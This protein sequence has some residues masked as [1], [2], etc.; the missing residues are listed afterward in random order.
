MSQSNGE[1][2]LL[3]SVEKARVNSR[4]TASACGIDGGKY[5]ALESSALKPKKLTF[6]NS[7]PRRQASTSEHESRPEMNGGGLGRFSLTLHA[8]MTPRND[9]LMTEENGTVDGGYDEEYKDVAIDGD[10]LP[11]D[12]GEEVMTFDIEV[13]QNNPRVDSVREMA[14]ELGAMDSRRSLSEILNEGDL[15]NV[16]QEE[17]LSLR[18]KVWQR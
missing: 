12:V 13:A 1:T 4:A 3:Q 6:G 5:A 16:H 14:S 11:V 17:D 8:C 10:E 9:I 2:I 7:P 18:E 15:A